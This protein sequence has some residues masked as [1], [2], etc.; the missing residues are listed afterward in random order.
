MRAAARTG[1]F[2]LLMALAL[3]VSPLLFPA[4]LGLLR[5]VDGEWVRGGLADLYRWRWARMMRGYL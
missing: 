2:R 5:V 1:A 4:L 3:I